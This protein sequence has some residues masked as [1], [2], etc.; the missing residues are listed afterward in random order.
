MSLRSGLLA[1]LFVVCGGCSHDTALPLPSVA[2]ANVPQHL[3][4]ARELLA[5]VPAG[6]TEYRHRPSVVAWGQTGQAECR[7]DCSGFVNAVLKRSMGLGDAELAEWLGR[8][9]PLAQDYE[10]AIAEGNGFDRVWRVP[11]VLAGDIIAVRYEADAN[12][13]GHVMI[14]DAGPREHAETAPVA[15]G[16][17]Q[18]EIAVIDVSN[19]GHGAGDS[20]RDV[21]GTFRGG[22]GRGV[23]RVYA[24]A[25]GEIA[26]YTV[27][28]SA[29]S[30]FHS[31]SD[32]PVV[33]GRVK[34]R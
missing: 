14:V 6:A 32:R 22:I 8:R 21:S 20:R 12:N 23:V 15:T 10:R 24:D 34:R 29:R 25:N 1:G 30:Q 11:D 2:P 16:L 9:R 5:E 19:A 31:A 18:W 3:M 17:T 26:G 13:T 27:S 33:V 4:L 7:T 28:A